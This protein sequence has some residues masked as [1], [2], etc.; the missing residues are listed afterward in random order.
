MARTR[1]LVH[2]NDAADRWIG[3]SVDRNG[4]R[5]IRERKETAGIEK[6]E[7]R[8]K[9]GTKEHRKRKKKAH[10]V[11]VFLVRLTAKQLTKKFFAV[12]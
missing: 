10:D 11:Q 2:R 3:K 7:T 6:E 9:E 1:I 4:T 12:M 8:D 5:E